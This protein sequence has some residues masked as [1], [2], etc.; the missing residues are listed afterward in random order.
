MPQHEPN[1]QSMTTPRRAAAAKKEMEGALTT[2]FKEHREAFTKVFK[3]SAQIFTRGPI[4]QVKDQNAHAC[5]LLHMP[6]TSA[7]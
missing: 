2:A 7:G 6:A 5:L 1:P 3:R 4:R